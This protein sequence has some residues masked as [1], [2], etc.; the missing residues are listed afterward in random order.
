MTPEEA[1][2]QPSPG[3]ENDFGAIG[4]GL[5]VAAGEAIA[6]I[7]VHQELPWLR[8]L[9]W[10]TFIDRGGQ[11]FVLEFYREWFDVEVEDDGSKMHW[12]CTDDFAGKVTRERVVAPD[13]AASPWIPVTERMPEEGREVLVCCESKYLSV[14]A[15]RSHGGFESCDG[16]ERG[17]GNVS[18]WAELRLPERT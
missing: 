1:L 15:R 4:P 6:C 12:K 14:A 3:P 5:R 13:P 10:V 8:R 17:I 18:H 9:G 11:W 2:L 16:C 7:G